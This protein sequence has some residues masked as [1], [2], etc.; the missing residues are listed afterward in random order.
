MIKKVIIGIVVV[1]IGYFGYGFMTH[2][3]HS[4]LT[5]AEGKSGDLSVSVDYCQPSKKGRLI[6]GN[7]SDDALVPNG[8][9][10]RLGAND[11]T[12]ITFSQDV[13]FAGEPIAAGRYRFYA[14][15]NA[16]NWELSLNSQ[17]GEFGF[18][19]PDYTLDV[20]KVKVPVKSNAQQLELL[21]MTFDSDSTGLQLNMAW[22]ETMVSVPISQQ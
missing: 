18:F 6:F 2:R 22:D 3:S 7:E 1:V 9:Y 13:N 11:A 14:V 10:W 17:L 21:T 4:P 20:L 19:E 12:E 5:S 16:D 8:K 15:P